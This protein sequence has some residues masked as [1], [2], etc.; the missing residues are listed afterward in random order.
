[1]I[2]LIVPFAYDDFLSIKIFSLVNMGLHVCCAAIALFKNKKIS[3]KYDLFDIPFCFL[4]S[5]PVIVIP[6]FWI[7]YIR[8]THSFDPI[9]ILFITLF[10]ILLIL[11]PVYFI[12]RWFYVNK[13]GYDNDDN[14]NVY[15]GYIHAALM[16]LM[17]YTPN[18]LQTLLIVLY[19]PI[20]FYFV[21]SCVFILVLSLTRSMSYF[22]D[23]VPDD[24][25]ATSTTYTQYLIQDWMRFN[26]TGE[27][28]EDKMMK[29]VKNND[30][31]IMKLVKTIENN[32]NE[33]K[34]MIR[35]NESEINRLTEIMNMMNKETKGQEDGKDTT[36][37][38]V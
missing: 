10:G 28:K 37:T 14:N 26:F 4:M 31:K 2:P 22:T 23:R 38:V 33:I 36:I 25:L 6:I 20:N 3:D 1:M 18:I 12:V 34:R 15:M 17:F 13:Y 5:F 29:I 7:V 11:A 9:G 24:F 30:E 32:E 27:K 35:N 8:I 21:K 19:W 16:A